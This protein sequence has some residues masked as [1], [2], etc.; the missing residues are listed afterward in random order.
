MD[1]SSYGLDHIS[2]KTV[3]NGQTIGYMTSLLMGHNALEFLRVDSKSDKGKYGTKY[4]SHCVLTKAIEN[5][6]TVCCV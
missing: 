6:R 1:K 3:I 5:G 4:L 2:L